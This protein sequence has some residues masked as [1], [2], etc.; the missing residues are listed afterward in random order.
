MPLLFALLCLFGI[1]AAR[2]TPEF[3]VREMLARF[4]ATRCS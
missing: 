1:I 2:I 3:L 4:A